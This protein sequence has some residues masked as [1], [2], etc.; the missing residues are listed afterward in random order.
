MILLIDNYDS[1]SYNLAQ[2]FGCLGRPCQV[3]R[4]HELDPSEVEAWLPEALVISPGPG[5]PG[6]FPVCLE[7]VRRL[8]GRTPMLGV[9][10]GHQCIAEAMGGRV[11]R[12]S[13]P[14]HGKVS[15]IYHDGRTLFEG[16][17]NPLEAARYHSLVVCEESLPESLEVSAF[18]AEGE[19]MGVR[20]RLLRL[21]GLQFHP[22]SIATP[23]GL[24]ILRNFLTFY[25][26]GGARRA[27]ERSPALAGTGPGR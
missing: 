10:L 2:A 3:R 23:V 5:R 24:E 8:A 27:P 15:V 14:V 6:D 18:T 11:I 4:P 12:A 20:S 22:E 7:L 25:L 26:P 1:F 9:C 19:V 17:R 16:L 21:E 13:V